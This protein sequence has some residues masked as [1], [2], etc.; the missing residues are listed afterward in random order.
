MVEPLGLHVHH[1][2]AEHLD[3]P[4]VGVPAEPLVAGE[5]D[6]PLER[7]LVQAEVQDRVHHPGHREL[8]PRADAHEERVRRVAEA[9]AGP[10]LD[11]AH[12]LQD[13]VPEPV[14]EL[15]A[16]GEV[17][18][19]GLGRDR[20]PGRRREAG[21]RHLGEAG[22]LAAEEVLHPAVALG[23][24]LAPGVDVALLRAVRTVGLGHGG[25]GHRDRLLGVGRRGHRRR[26]WDRFAN[27][28]R[29]YP[30]SRFASGCGTVTRP[31]SADPEPALAAG[32]GRPV[33]SRRH[34]RSC[35][36]SAR[37]RRGVARLQRE[38][39]P[40]RRR[41]RVARLLLGPLRR[42]ADA[43]R[44]RPVHDDR[45]DGRRQDRAAAVLRGVAAGQ[46]RH[47]RLRVLRPAR[48]GRD[49]HA[50][51]VADAGRPEDADDRP[52]GQVHARAGRRADAHLHLVRDRQRA[53]RLD[54]EAGAR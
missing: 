8:R 50:A 52:E 44:A 43:V 41:D 15:L 6:Q 26:I 35:R 32:T 12:R 49:V 37:H 4:P 48:P 46:R 14:R 25:R 51:A 5:G 40:A 2:P 45:R 36:R 19:A 38:P 7:L 54:D 53:L 29:L 17:V 10:P 20:E 1:D 9:L 11:L 34:D 31:R 22:A 47:G 18:V 42:R 23:R 30:W 16:G 24:A 3:E 21:D 33:P 39:R 13:V 28:S 27:C